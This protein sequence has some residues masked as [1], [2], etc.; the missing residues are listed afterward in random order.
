MEAELKDLCQQ[1]NA[2]NLNLV[3]FK[4]CTTNRPNLSNI[5]H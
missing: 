2:L 3:I 1:A 5:G 4:T